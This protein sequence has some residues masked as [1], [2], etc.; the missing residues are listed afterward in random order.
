MIRKATLLAVLSTALLLPAV[1]TTAGTA[2]AGQ[3]SR[4]TSKLTVQSI[5]PEIPTEPTQELKLSGT[6]KNGTGAPLANVQVRLRPSRQPFTDRAALAAS[7]QSGLVNDYASESY[8]TMIP[9]VEA[10]GQADWTITATPAQ[11]QMVNFGVYPLGVEV[12]ANGQQVALQRTYI[13]YTPETMPK[14]PRNRLSVALPVIDKRPPHRAADNTFLDDDLRTDLTGDGR[15][16]DLLKIAQSA[17]ESVT[18]FVDPALFDDAAASSKVPEAAAWLEGMKTALS[19]SPVIAL[20]YADPD[21]AALAHQGLDDQTGKAIEVGAKSARSQIKQ[22]VSTKTYWPVDGMIDADAL[23]LMSVGKVSSVLLDP[24]N[25]PLDP[26]V[27]TT[28]DATTTLDTVAGPV[29]AFVADKTLSQTFELDSNTTSALNRQRFIAE[30]ALIAAEPGQT[31]PRSLVIAPSRRWNPSPSHVTALLKTAGTLPWLSMTPLGSIKPT[32][33]PAPRGELTYPEQN[34]DKELGK[35]YLDRVKKVATLAEVATGITKDRVDGGY[36]ES[37]LRMTSSAW[38]NRLGAARA[39]T[40]KVS[41]SLKAD[42]EQV[43]ITGPE[44]VRTLAGSEGEVPISV[45]NEHADK[46]IVVDVFVTS[47]NP[48]LLKVMLDDENRRLTIGARQSGGVQVRM[49]A[50]G[51]G[52]ATVT[53]QLK[54]TDGLPYDDPVKLTVRTTGYT[55]IALVIVGAALTVMLAAVVT[56]VVRRRSQRR[57]ARPVRARESEPV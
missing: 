50:T 43:R 31:K 49:E 25:L 26:T 37:V 39:A 19:A 51:N 20:P 54:T 14:L 13:T 38:R 3:A 24:A 2:A 48:D 22:D 21:I 1:A 56:R 34:R 7:V 45:R 57:P 41:G 33:T 12:V 23:D 32:K 17:P 55:G 16:A 53:V 27:T 28:P 18:W 29:T 35:K 6:F 10:D 52:D 46:D 36:D 11:L 8:F 30:T 4:E 44:Q 40:A 15:L 5:T 42:I 9:S 47:N